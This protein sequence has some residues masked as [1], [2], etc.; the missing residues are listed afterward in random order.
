MSHY[1]IRLSKSRR[2]F[3][4]REPVQLN[5]AVYHSY[6]CLIYSAYTSTLIV[7][8]P[9]ETLKR[10]ALVRSFDISSPNRSR[11]SSLIPSTRQ[12]RAFSV[13]GPCIWDGLPL[14]Q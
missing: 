9:N 1:S 5:Q 7:H 12:T 2:D 14:A 6:L 10:F 4:V 8:V 13:V 3:Q 11:L